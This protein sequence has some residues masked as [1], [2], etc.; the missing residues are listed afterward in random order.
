AMAGI[1]EVNNDQALAVID[2]LGA[3]LSAH[4]PFGVGVPDYVRQVLVSTLGEEQGRT[5]ADRVLGDSQPVEIDNLRWLDFDT[6][7]H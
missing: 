3:A 2:G 6:V 5:L 4:T 1:R 7:V